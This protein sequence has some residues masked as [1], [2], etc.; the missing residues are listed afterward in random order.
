MIKILIKCWLVVLPWKLRRCILVK[1]YDYSI[2]KTAKIG[3]SWIF[4]KK[5]EMGPYSVI[6]NLTVCKEGLEI[7][8]MEEYSIISNLNFITGFPLNSKAAHF[9]HIS[10]RNPALFLKKHSAITSRHLIDCTETVVIGEFSTIAGFR[11]QILTHS[12]DL[13]ENRQSA[14]KIT[15]G[16]YCF[17]GTDCVLLGGSILPDYS[18]FGAKSL[19]NKSYFDVYSLYAGVPAKFVKKI[20]QDNKYFKR[21]FGAVE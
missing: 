8:K 1:F 20:D 10:D 17:I 12:I 9:Q 4:P 18:V 15:I 7:L 21:E 19:I 3:F 5:L 13:V 16:N 14:K 6:G 11:S 2:D